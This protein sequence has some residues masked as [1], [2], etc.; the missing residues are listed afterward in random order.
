M[1]G[2]S[3]AR[4]TS[5]VASQRQ[6]A[7]ALR[8]TSTACSASIVALAS[9]RAAFTRTTSLDPFTARWSASTFPWKDPVVNWT[10]TWPP[11]ARA[12]A[13][14][15]PTLRS[16]ARIML[17]SSMATSGSHQTRLLMFPTK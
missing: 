7:A 2:E 5:A 8:T 17:T 9:H 1:H 4:I 11:V 16:W 3:V 14:A 15:V 10:S 13:W 6:P 12:V